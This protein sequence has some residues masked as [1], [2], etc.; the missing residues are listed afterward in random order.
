VLVASG[1]IEHRLDD[2]LLAAEENGLTV[3]TVRVEDG[4]AAIIFEK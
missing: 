1:I 2:V 3:K 4:W